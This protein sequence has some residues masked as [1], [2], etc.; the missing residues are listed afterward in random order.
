M[1]VPT[2]MCAAGFNY[3]AILVFILAYLVMMLSVTILKKK[4]SML[5]CFEEYFL[6]FFCDLVGFFS[7]NNFSLIDN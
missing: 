3:K 2:F 4:K 1:I 6:N 7:G 5:C